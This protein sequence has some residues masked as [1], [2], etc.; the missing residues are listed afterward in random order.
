MTI[1]IDMSRIITA[2]DKST[3]ERD[4]RVSA[5]RT[6]CKQRITAHCSNT[7]QINL[8]AAAAAGLLEND[9][10][11]L[12]RRFLSWTAQ[13][14]AAWGPLAEGEQ[15]LSQ[16]RYW[17]DLSPE[18]AAFLQRRHDQLEIEQTV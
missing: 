17:P 13:M 10:I 4:E 3:T 6:A 12:Y 2:E 7:D 16:D 14:R 8:S 9:D 15:D 18:V 5:A 1:T 11:D